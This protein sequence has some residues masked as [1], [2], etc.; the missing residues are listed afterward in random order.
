VFEY[1]IVDAPTIDA[2]EAMVALMMNKD[3]RPQGGVAISYD[4]RFYQ[5]MWKQK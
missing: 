2:L 3:W 5:A 1:R 4:G